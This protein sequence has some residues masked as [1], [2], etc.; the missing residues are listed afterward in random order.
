MLIDADQTIDGFNRSKI[1]RQSNTAAQNRAG[2]ALVFVSELFQ[3]HKKKGARRRLELVGLGRSNVLDG[4]EGFG[5]A[6]RHIDV[7][8]HSDT[9]RTC[10]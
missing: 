4:R 8:I 5:M 10:R 2:F 7:L 3:L 6:N 1:A 9:N